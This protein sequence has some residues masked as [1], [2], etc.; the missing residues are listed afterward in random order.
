MTDR[1]RSTP[2]TLAGSLLL[3]HPVL[4]D[5]NFRRAV[6]LMSAHNAEGA[7]GVVL[8]RP[9]GKSLAELDGGFAL[10]DLASVP[11]Y[12]GGPV[13]DEQLILVAWQPQPDGFRLHFGLD[14]EKAML[15]AGEEGTQVRGFL[16]YA[17]WSAGQLEGEMERK[18]WIVSAA[19]PD[20]LQHAPDDSLWSVVLGEVDARWKLLANEPDDTTLN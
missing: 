19:P 12:R 20:L 16:G 2:E 4:R 15:L 9:A 5:P 8:N 13:Q 1:P 3:A 7:M 11:I 18:T 6:I 10:T 17:G 14:P